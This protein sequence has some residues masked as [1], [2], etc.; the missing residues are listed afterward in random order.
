MQK[1]GWV[2]RAIPDAQLDGFVEKL[3][4]RFS[5]FDKTA[6]ITTKKQ[7]IGAT[8][9]KEADRLS[10]YAEFTKSLSWLGLQQRM[11]MFGKMYQEVGLEKVESNMGFYLG[12]GNRKLQE[13]A[14]VKK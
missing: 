3:A 7:I 2:T 5:S 8:F 1:Y 10:S 13:S 9:P 12:E 6:L 14:K 4:N 11:P